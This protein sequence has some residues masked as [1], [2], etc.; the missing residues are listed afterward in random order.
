MLKEMKQTYQ[1]WLYVA[2]IEYNKR[3]L[4]IHL[5]DLD[6]FQV[7]NDLADCIIIECNVEE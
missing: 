3:E 5:P 1:V 2:L 6:F 7:V 4:R